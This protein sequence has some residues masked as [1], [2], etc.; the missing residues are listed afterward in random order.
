MMHT[1]KHE[2]NILS[3]LSMSLVSLACYAFVDDTDVVHSACTNSIQGEEVIP[4]M[5]EV[6]DCWEGGLRAT[7]GALVPSKSYWYLLDFKWRHGK[8]LYPWI[9]DI[10]GNIYIQ[11]SDGSRVML[12]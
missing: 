12:T 9:Q 3:T 11:D 8:W 7:G 1:H 2:V 5:Q 4:E 6:V 10:P